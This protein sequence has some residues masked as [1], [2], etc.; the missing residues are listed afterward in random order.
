[1]SFMLRSFISSSVV[2]VMDL[3]SSSST[4]DFEFLKSKREASSFFTC[5]TALTTSCLSYS[6]TI[7]KLQSLAIILP[8][9]FDKILP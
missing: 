7:S 8:S 4:V 2:I 5:S 6:D 9:L 3:P 1:M